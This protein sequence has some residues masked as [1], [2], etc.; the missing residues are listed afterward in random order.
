MKIVLNGSDRD[1]ES[2]STLA[3]LVAA[4]G[5]AE[6]RVAIELNREKSRPIMLPLANGNTIKLDDALRIRQAD[7]DGGYEVIYRAPKARFGPSLA[8]EKIA[9]GSVTL[10]VQCVGRPNKP[11]ERTPIQLDVVYSFTRCSFGFDQ[12]K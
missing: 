11:K 4:A 9:N 7:E 5:L 1:V 10:P 2:G 3:D 6:R 8:I 12:C